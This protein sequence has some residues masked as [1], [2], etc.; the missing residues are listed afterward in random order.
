MPATSL[1][2]LHFEPGG[3]VTGPG[4]IFTP[5]PGG[6]RAHLH[7]RQPYTRLTDPAEASELTSALLRDDRL[8]HHHRRPRRTNLPPGRRFTDVQASALRAI[9]AAEQATWTYTHAPDHLRVIPQD[10]PEQAVHYTYAAAISGV[11]FDV[12]H[13]AFHAMLL[14]LL[15]QQAALLA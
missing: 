2:D 8:W 3:D 13:G 6:W 10:T 14:S 11:E 1:L 7:A 15:P 4:L 12:T 5:H 9:S